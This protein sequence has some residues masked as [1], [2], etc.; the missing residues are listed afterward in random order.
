MLQLSEK[1]Y[2]VI[3][4]GDNP[5]IYT[6]SKSKHSTIALFKEKHPLLYKNQTEYGN[7]LFVNWQVN[8]VELDIKLS[9]L[10]V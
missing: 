2:C 9:I 4:L 6:L 3:Y 5:L 7:E 10:D 8:V 1:E